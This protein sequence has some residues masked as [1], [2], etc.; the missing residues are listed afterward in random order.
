MQIE[1]CDEHDN[2]IVKMNKDELSFITGIRFGDR[3][4]NCGKKF[5]KDLIGKEFD[6]DEM[7]DKSRQL[8]TLAEAKDYIAKR[9]RQC[10][11]EVD[12]QFMWP[13]EIKKT[14]EKL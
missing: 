6:L 1:Y 5:S 2:V 12:A 3:Y 4:G 8:Q 13:L 7:M 10:A 14:K 9:M 11:D